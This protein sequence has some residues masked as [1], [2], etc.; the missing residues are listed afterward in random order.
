MKITNKLL[1]HTIY[2]VL[3]QSPHWG[4][5]TIKKEIERFIRKVTYTTIANYTQGKTKEYLPVVEIITLLGKEE[6]L[7][8]LRR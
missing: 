3:N 8:R 1:I 5:V 7:K 2:D 6:T 4:K